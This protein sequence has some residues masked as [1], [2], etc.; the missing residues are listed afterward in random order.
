MGSKFTNSQPPQ[1]QEHNN[2]NSEPLLHNEYQNYLNSFCLRQQTVI[3]VGTR[4][5]RQGVDLS[6]TQQFLTRS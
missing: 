3:L 5:V 6:F 4:T 1:I 2:Y